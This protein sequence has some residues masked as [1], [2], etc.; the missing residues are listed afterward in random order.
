MNGHVISRN[1][2]HHG[3]GRA[4]WFPALGAAAS[5]IV[6]DISLD[7]DFHRLVLAFADKR[8]AGKAA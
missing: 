7:A 6:G 2:R 4:S 5:V 3:E 8:S 1:H